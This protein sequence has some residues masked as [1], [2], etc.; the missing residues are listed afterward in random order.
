[1]LL[2]HAINPHGFAW[3]R[4]TTEEGVDLNRNCVGFAPPP[5]NHAY[6]E[7]ADAFVPPDLG[8]E[9]LAAAD[10]VLSRWRS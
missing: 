8:P 10:A 5:A 3:L 7:L 4:R 9:T 6:A 1:M 2:V